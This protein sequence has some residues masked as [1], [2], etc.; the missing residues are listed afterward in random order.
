[1]AAEKPHSTEIRPD[2]W[3]DSRRALWLR[4]ARILVLADIHWGYVASHRARGNLLPH[5]GDEDIAGRIQTLIETYEP[6]EMI[7]LGDSLHSLSGRL[8]A[9]RFIEATRTP[10]SIL[11]GNHDFRWERASEK[12]AIRGPFFL[13]HGHGK[14]EV[15][16]GSVEVIG[17]HHPAV[18]WYDRAGGRLKVAA[19]VDGPHRLI[20]PA[21]SPWA[22]GTPWNRR[23]LEGEV[24]WAVSERRVFKMDIAPRG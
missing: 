13:H 19:L 20:L 15:P 21:F 14:P 11:A 18:S 7:W 23:L 4:A 3:I 1:M 9:D 5:W 10:I 6:A 12:T 22:S 24:L 8:E 2:V 16:T 17:H